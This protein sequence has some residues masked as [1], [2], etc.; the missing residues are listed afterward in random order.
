MRFAV[1]GKSIGAI[2]VSGSLNG[3]TD[4]PLAGDADALK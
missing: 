4:R 2:G 1:D 3:P